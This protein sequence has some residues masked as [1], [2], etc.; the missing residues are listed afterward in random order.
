MNQICNSSVQTLATLFAT[1]YV[2]RLR[3]EETTRQRSSGLGWFPGAICPVT[4]DF[5][6]VS[7]GAILIYSNI[8]YE[9]MKLLS[10]TYVMSLREVSSTRT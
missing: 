2:Y 1:L 9:T 5:T 6:Q 4:S 8:D 10:G 3:L 7:I